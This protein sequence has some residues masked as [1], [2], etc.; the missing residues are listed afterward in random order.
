MKYKKGVFYMTLK[1]AVNELFD[2]AKAHE[3]DLDVAYAK[4]AHEIKGDPEHFMKLGDLSEAYAFSKAHYNTIV[5]AR[6][7]GNDEKYDEALKAWEESNV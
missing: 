7:S 5:E 2:F 4:K 1:N 3:C 6:K